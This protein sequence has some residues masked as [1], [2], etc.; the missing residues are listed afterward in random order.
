M[1]QSPSWEANWFAASQKFPLET[2]GPVK[3]CNGIALTLPLF[4]Y[5]LPYSIEQSPSWE[6]NR[7]A[8]SQDIPLILLNP[9]VHYRIHKCPPPV[10]ILNQF[11][12]IHTPTSYFLKIH[13]YIIL[14]S[15]PGS[16]QWLFP[17]GF[18]T[19][20]IYTPFPF[21][22]RDTFPAFLIL[23]DFITCTMVREEYRSRSFSI[24]SCFTPLLPC[25]T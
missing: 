25:P 19:K 16:P 22:I 2:S 13:L 5:L 17:S 24:W 9:K 10:L 14:P 3:A 23:L 8:S 7:F 1:E 6:V 20:T 4:T 18:P 12:P 15:T 11:N 21:P